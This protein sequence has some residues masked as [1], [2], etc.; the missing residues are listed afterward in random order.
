[1]K[2]Y[3]HKNITY[4]NVL[5]I[6]PIYL[7]WVDITCSNPGWLQ[8][9]LA[10]GMAWCSCGRFDNIN[11]DL[12]SGRTFT[13]CLE[14]GT[15][16]W[17]SHPLVARC[18]FTFHWCF[19]SGT[20][21]LLEC[22]GCQCSERNKSHGLREEEWRL[23]IAPR[24]SWTS[25][26]QFHERIDGFGQAGKLLRLRCLKLDKTLQTG[27]HAPRETDKPKNMQKC[28]HQPPVDFPPRTARW[29][30][31]RVVVGHTPKCWLVYLASWPLWRVSHLLID[32][33][34]PFPN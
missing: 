33:F 7:N 29:V 25:V 19:I 1:M 30:Q 2:T 3:H 31:G 15:M 27:Q 11:S 6:H 16:K 32:V 12:V 4:Q 24:I 28:K 13:M 23:V 14:I 8:W 9:T 5:C 26:H 22:S 34:I 21:W 20:I 18:R 10:G 17:R